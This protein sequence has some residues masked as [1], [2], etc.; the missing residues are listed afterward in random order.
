MKKIS[1][2]NRFNNG[3][4]LLEVLVS[5][6]IVGALLVTVIYTLNYHLSL[7]N[8]NKSLTIATFL[9]KDK[10]REMEINQ[11]SSKGHFKDQYNDYIYETDVK[12]SQY[13]GIKEIIVT[14]RHGKEEVKLNEFIYKYENK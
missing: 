7:V 2:V 6:S 8:K 12:D 1:I 14:V 4:T 9:A 13:P 3:F 10:L 5:I 11:I